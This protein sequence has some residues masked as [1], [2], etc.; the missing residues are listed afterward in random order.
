M[1]VWTLNESAL[2][3]GAWGVYIRHIQSH[4]FS[5]S[6]GMAYYSGKK[7]EFLKVVEHRAQKAS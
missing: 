7:P 5:F 1:R 3:E 2:S 4:E 6:G